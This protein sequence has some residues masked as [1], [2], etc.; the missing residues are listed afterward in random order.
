M[1]VGE[2]IQRVRKQQNLTQKE[3]GK[4]CGIAEPTIRRYELGKLK[5]KIT[6]VS[7][8]AEALGVEILELTSGDPNYP[9]TFKIPTE[10][11]DRKLEQRDQAWR[12]YIARRFKEAH[13]WKESKDR[14][15]LNA[16]LAQ[17]NDAGIEKAADV[18][19]IIAEVPRYRA[20]ASLQPPAAPPDG[21]AAPPPDVPET[22][23]EGEGPGEDTSIKCIEKSS[24]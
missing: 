6:T 7:R 8:I 2:R 16:A 21:A 18:V 17:L 1:T 19:E 4:R 10:E 20:E 14:D 15:R 5:P 12:D 23:P 13:I 22:P 11:L 9:I 24:E 3:L